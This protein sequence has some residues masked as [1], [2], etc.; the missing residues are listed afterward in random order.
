M[1]AKGPSKSAVAYVSVV[2]DEKETKGYMLK[3]SKSSVSPNV[4]NGSSN[5]WKKRFFVLRGSTLNYY[6]DQNATKSKGELLVFGETQL[7]SGSEN[8]QPYCITIWEPFSVLQLA[9]ASP[10]DLQVWIAAF[11]RSMDIGK[12]ALRNNMYRKA[13]LQ[14]GGTKKKYF[15]LHSD[16]ITYHKDKTQLLNVQGLVH[17][18]KNTDMEYNDGKVP[19]PL[20][21]SSSLQS[22]TILRSYY[23]S[24]LL[25]YKTHLRATACPSNFDPMVAAKMVFIRNGRRR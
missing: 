24:C 18:D 22:L 5:G 20:S 16:V 3:F 8:G 7:K 12:R 6:S 9:C 17:M 1:S 4:S 2:S 19:R 23:Y 25:T 10:A 15:I 13:L 14:D 11:T 21:P